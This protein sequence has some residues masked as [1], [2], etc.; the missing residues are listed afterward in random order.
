MVDVPFSSFVPR[1]RGFELDGPQ[2]DS[3]QIT[4]MGLMIYDKKDGPFE[5]HLDSVSA[6]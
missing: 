1:V 4:G 5:L 6:Y 3:S 2:L